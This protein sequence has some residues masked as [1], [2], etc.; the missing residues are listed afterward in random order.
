M[1]SDEANVILF[2]KLG[3]IP[4][5]N[6]DLDNENPP[7]EVSEF[8]KQLQSVDGIL[9]FTPEYAWVFLEH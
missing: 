2:Q 8:R 9:I 5:F 6:P 7:D 4:H 1:F 3:S